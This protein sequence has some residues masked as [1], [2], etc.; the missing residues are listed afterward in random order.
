MEEDHRELLAS[1]RKDHEIERLNPQGRAPL[2]GA[3][4]QL[5]PQPIADDRLAG[6]AQLSGHPLQPEELIAVVSCAQG[7]AQRALAIGPEPGQ[8]QGDLM[9]QGRV[10]S[11]ALDV[12][13]HPLDLVLPELSEHLKLGVEL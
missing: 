9:S 7:S 3:A 5:V 12:S 10:S 6:L 13:L 11:Q 2:F 1:A 8:S 4:Q